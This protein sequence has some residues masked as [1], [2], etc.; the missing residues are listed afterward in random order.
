MIRVETDFNRMD[1]PGTLLIFNAIEKI[2]DRYRKEGTRILLHDSEGGLE[3]EAVL[4]RG[5]GD[6]FW[7]ADIVDGTLTREPD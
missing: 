5:P 6:N 1:G 3:C 7:L 4:R 2:P